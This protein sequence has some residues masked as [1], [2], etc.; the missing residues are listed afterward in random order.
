MQDKIK[1]LREETL[2]QEYEV[3]FGSEELQNI[4]KTLTLQKQTKSK[5]E[6]FRP[7]KVPLNV[8]FR[9]NAQEIFT[10]SIERLLSLTMKDVVKDQILAGPLAYEIVSEFNF[11]SLED[12]APLTMRVCVDYF[13]SIPEVDWQAI[14]LD[15]YQV[16]PTD[17]EVEK[18][19]EKQAAQNIR[20]VPLSAPRPAKEGDMLIYEMRFVDQNGQEQVLQK[21]GILNRDMI[22]KA[23]EKK[24]KKSKVNGQIFDNLLESIEPGYGFNEKLSKEDA[25]NIGLPHLA[26]QEISIQVKEV[27]ETVPCVADEV[28]AQSQGFENLADYR[29]HVRNK[30]IQVGHILDQRC[31]KHQLSDK[32]DEVLNFDVPS[33]LVEKEYKKAELKK[34]QNKE[35]KNLSEDEKKTLRDAITQAFRQTFLWEH[36]VQNQ[37]VEITE[38]EWTNHFYRMAQSHKVPV[39][40]MIEYLHHHESER[41]QALN[42]LRKEK[43]VRWACQQAQGKPQ[44]ISFFELQKKFSGSSQNKPIIIDDGEEELET[45]E[46]EKMEAEEINT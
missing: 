5:K 36:L 13:P 42:N 37:K 30:L 19:V 29:E 24:V 27:Q 12:L 4:A 8:V 2:S 25:K 7:G 10:Q 35:D 14:H 20:G 15:R 33:F 6:G 45:K 41:H 32:L 22:T 11:S 21:A 26:N 28:F 39:E 9:E 46:I 18:E 3:N 38:Q 23:L 44:V 43:L 40:A 16:T 1:L 17:E 34:L 31:Q